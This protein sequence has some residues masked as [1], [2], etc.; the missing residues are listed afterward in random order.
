MET[1]YIIIGGGSA[2]CV[3]ANRL[4]ADPKVRVTLVEAGGEDWNPLIHI[5]ATYIKTMVNPSINWMF[6]AKP[7]DRTGQRSIGYCQTKL[8]E[9]SGPTF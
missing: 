1:D 2:G 5:P 3:L 9:T 4:S 6:T 7:D 8:L